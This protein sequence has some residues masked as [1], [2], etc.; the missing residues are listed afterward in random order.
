M[1][2][3]NQDIGEILAG[4]DIDAMFGELLDALEVDGDEADVH[5]DV[6][7]PSEELVAVA[8]RVSGQYVEILAMVSAQLLA[9]TAHVGAADQLESALDALRR[10]VVVQ[11]ADETL[12]LI[13]EMIA[14]C[15]TWR[16]AGPGRRARTRFLDTLRAWL[17][18]LARALGPEEGNRLRNLTEY[19]PG[20][21]PL[22][23]ELE[24]IR[25]MGPKR[26]QR[27]YC[28]GLFTVDA[29]SAADPVEV[30][31]V[32]GLPRELTTQ[33]VERTRTFATEHRRRTIASM[34][35]R[36]GEFARLVQEID[37][38][39]EPELARLARTAVL[40]MRRLVQE[41]LKGSN[42]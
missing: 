14:A 2:P 29:L 20:A 18:R 35:Q 25:G 38:R 3:D 4:F 22:F 21:V 40:E 16:T 11:E 13:D 12:S 1:M 37:P 34:Q 30:S 27:L 32:T 42:L 9:G 10:L 26:L 36:L 28:A 24:G 33:I 41:E 17:P 15:S 39:R 23:S 5:A 31:Q 19:D 8:Q 6:D 7:V